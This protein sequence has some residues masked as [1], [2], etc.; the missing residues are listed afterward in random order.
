MFVGEILQVSDTVTTPTT[1]AEGTNKITPSSSDA[2]TSTGPVI[3]VRNACQ[4]S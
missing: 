3:G 1:T 4:Q 2:L